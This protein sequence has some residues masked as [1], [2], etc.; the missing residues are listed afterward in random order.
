MG[1]FP[2][3]RYND[4]PGVNPHNTTNKIDLT[5]TSIYEDENGRIWLA[6][7]GALHCHNIEKTK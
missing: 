1:F 7:N 4:K 5:V 3:Q 6:G 2:F